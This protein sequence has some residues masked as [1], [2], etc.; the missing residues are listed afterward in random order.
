MSCP[1]G[2][3]NLTTFRHLGP[4]SSRAANTLDPRVDSD[5]DNRGATGT[6]GMTGSHGVTGSYGSTGTHGTNLGSA[7][8]THTGA[9]TGA[10]TGTHMGSHG[11]T[12]S[13]G[14]GPAPNTAGP[15]KSDMLNKM[16]PRVDSDMSKGNN[17]Y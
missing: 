11:T 1:Y 17:S 14:T 15:H 13:V 10:H 9:H 16:D 12:T 7:T 3:H 4:H 2:Y 6:H 5:L 8:G